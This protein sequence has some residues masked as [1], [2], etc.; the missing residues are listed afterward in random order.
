MSDKGV[1]FIPRRGGT[2]DG[3]HVAHGGFHPRRAP[4]LASGV[5]GK[6]GG[7]IKARAGDRWVGG[8]GA[9]DCEWDGGGGGGGG[10]GGERRVR[11]GRT[12]SIAGVGEHLS[13]GERRRVWVE[14]GV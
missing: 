10:E 14:C 13:G 12:P 5:E 4:P 6:G 2:G 9:V 7:G 8:A 3:G 11:R 1:T